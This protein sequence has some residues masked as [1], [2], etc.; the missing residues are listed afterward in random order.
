LG[1]FCEDDRF[2]L[3]L[4]WY[5]TLPSHVQLVSLHDVLQYVQDGLPRP[6]PTFLCV[7]YR[8]SIDLYSCCVLYNPRRHKIYLYTH[9]RRYGLYGL[10][11]ELPRIRPSPPVFIAPLFNYIYAK[12][13]YLFISQDR[14]VGGGGVDP[15]GRSS[16]PLPHG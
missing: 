1:A 4:Y 7:Y 2:S 9:I 13:A 14:V 10:E 12:L 16:T 8:Q 5:S 6:F 3:F 15:E 11:T